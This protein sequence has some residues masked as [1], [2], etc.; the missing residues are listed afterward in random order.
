VFGFSRVGRQAFQVI[1]EAVIDGD[2]RHIRAPRPVE[3]F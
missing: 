1:D 3:Q 2:W